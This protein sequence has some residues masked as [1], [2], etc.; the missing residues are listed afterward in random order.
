MQQWMESAAKTLNGWHFLSFPK[1]H[2]PELEAVRW[3]AAVG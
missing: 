2:H 3:W 1:V